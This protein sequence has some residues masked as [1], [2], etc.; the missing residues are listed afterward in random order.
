LENIFHEKGRISTWL[1]VIRSFT[2]A[3]RLTLHNY[4]GDPERESI[5]RNV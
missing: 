5:S 1:Y 3:M 4:K 2:K